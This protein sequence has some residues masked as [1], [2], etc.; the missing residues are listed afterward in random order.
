MTH[1]SEIVKSTIEAIKEYIKESSPDEES[2][3]SEI[4]NR[5]ISIS[6]SPC[7]KMYI[8]FNSL[9]SLKILEELSTHKSLLKSLSSDPSFATY[10]LQCSVHFFTAAHPELSKA[11]PT[12]LKLVYDFDLL[13]ED[14][15]VAWE[16]KKFKTD[17]KSFLYSKKAEKK[18]KKAGEQFF[19]WLKE[20]E[21]EESEESEEEE[22]KAEVTE[23][24]LKK[25]KMKELIQREKEKQEK[26][27]EQAKKVQEEKEAL[28][29]AKQED[30]EEGDKIDVLKVEVDGDDGDIDIDD[31]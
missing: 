11:I 12:F 3:K 19:T 13:E 17:K 21:S 7:L 18:F 16:G 24:E 29:E 6:A 2:L 5:C 10:F 26:E 15:L 9:F 22:E 28:E 4:N 23:E 25:Q 8:T 30:R 31:I 20:A 27:L 1:E 14:L